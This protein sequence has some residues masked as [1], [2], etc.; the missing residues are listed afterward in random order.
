MQLSLIRC[1]V[2][3]GELDPEILY[4][5]VPCKCVLMLLA[6]WCL[7]HVAKSGL[8][9]QPRSDGLH[10]MASGLEAIGNE[11]HLFIWNKRSASMQTVDLPPPGYAPASRAFSVSKT[12]VNLAPGSQLG[13]CG[14]M[15]F[16]TFVA[17]L[18]RPWRPG[19]PRSSRPIAPF[20]AMPLLLVASCQEERGKEEERAK[21]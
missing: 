6:D 20:V 3:Q 17:S 10:A 2:Y 13:G 16:S 5:A 4:V 19:A 7:P 9:S 8:T 12:R 11:L 14:R 15:T 1:T 18:L 21:G